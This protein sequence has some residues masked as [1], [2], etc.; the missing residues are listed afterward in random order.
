MAGG[1]GDPTPGSKATDSAV[2]DLGSSADSSVT[3]CVPSASL[4]LLRSHFPHLSDVDQLHV[5]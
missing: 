3:H 2:G 4:G 1:K 5:F